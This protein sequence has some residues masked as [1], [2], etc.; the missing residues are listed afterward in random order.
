MM[1]RLTILLLVLA[2]L[3][4]AGTAQAASSAWKSAGS[5]N[6]E[7]AS[8]WL[9][10]APT[11]SGT[12]WCFASGGGTSNITVGGTGH[13][14][15]NQGQLYLYMAYNGTPTNV[16]MTSTANATLTINSGATISTS[17]GTLMWSTQAGATSTI[18]IYGTYSSTT[19]TSNA[20]MTLASGTNSTGTMKV[21]VENGGVF[22]VNQGGGS[23]TGLQMVTSGTTASNKAEVDIFYGG[24]ANVKQ[25]TIGTAGTGK[26]YLDTSGSV[27]AQA[28][29]LW[30]NGDART[31]VGTDITG[32]KIQKYDFT[33]STA[34]D[35][36]S[37]ADPSTSFASADLAHYNY[38]YDTALGK[39]WVTVQT[40]EPATIA[41]LG[42]GS[43]MLL[44]RKR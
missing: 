34:T 6:W 28:A 3:G 32:H 40:P 33:T 13:T 21:K 1:K 29:I 10:Q 15:T 17:R 36:V 22:N 42:L 14:G 43:L 44:R 30:L 2:V 12:T 39:T 31:Q 41:I 25:Y 27:Q 16:T 8:N 37:A 5:G 19:T 24:I 4:V 11:S 38:G 20:N 9:Q 35:M 18:D 26:I 7:D 23:G